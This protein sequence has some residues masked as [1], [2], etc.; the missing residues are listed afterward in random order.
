MSAEIH[1]A[2]A[3]NAELLAN[4]AEDVLDEDILPE[5]LSLFLALPGH[6]MFL[7]V[8][9][10]AVVGQIRGMV[11]FQPDRASDLYID[12]L[13]VAA[14]YQRRGI[15]TQLINALIAWG[16]GQGRKLCLGRGAT[17]QC[18]RHQLL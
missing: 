13:G 2:A 1:C 15:A 4:V 14:A 12:N 3:D 7:A 5:R 9:D 11:Y 18:R 10:G 16:E 8:E 17:R 6:V